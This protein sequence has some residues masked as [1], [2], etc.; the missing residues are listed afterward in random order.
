MIHPEHYFPLAMMALNLGASAVYFRKGDPWM[1]TYWLAALMLN[2]VIAF[3][4]GG[5]PP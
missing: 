3:R 4:P 5:N 1:A 2:F